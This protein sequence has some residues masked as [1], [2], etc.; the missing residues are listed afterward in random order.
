MKGYIVE[1]KFCGA[2][3]FIKGNDFH[4]ACKLFAVDPNFWKLI[5]EI[6]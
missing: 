4:H 5:S 2:R 1:H 3:R 6:C